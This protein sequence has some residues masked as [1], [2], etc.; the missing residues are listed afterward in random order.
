MYQSISPH[1]EGR[2]LVKTVL[3]TRPFS[4]IGIQLCLYLTHQLSSPGKDP[5]EILMK[6]SWL[7]KNPRK[8]TL[9]GVGGYPREQG[10][11]T[12]PIDQSTRSPSDTILHH[13]DVIQVEC[14]NPEVQNPLPGIVAHTYN[15]STP[16]AEVRGLPRQRFKI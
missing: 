13:K 5:Q 7:K 3:F 4:E 1:W 9:I 16:E 11:A 2:I 14:T 15:P 8:I 10:Q 12:V 6:F